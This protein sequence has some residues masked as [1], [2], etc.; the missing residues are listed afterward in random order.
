METDQVVIP[1][2]SRDIYKAL[3]DNGANVMYK[4]YA[5]VE[6]NAWTS[7]YFRKRLLSGC[8]PANARELNLAESLLIQGTCSGCQL[9]DFQGC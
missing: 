5:G 7:M 4:E 9:P 6:H 3:K 2:F 8:F 1:Q